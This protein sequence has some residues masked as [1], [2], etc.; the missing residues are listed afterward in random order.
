MDLGMI[1]FV[2]IDSASGQ[3]RC[4]G[5]VTDGTYS[6]DATRGPFAGKYRVEI[7]WAKKTGRKVS[8]GDGGMQDETTEGLPG[9][10]N[11]NTELTVDITSWTKKADFNLTP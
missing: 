10:F 3:T 5:K 9:R 1:T 6:L 4:G 8:N 11:K 2:P 7:Y